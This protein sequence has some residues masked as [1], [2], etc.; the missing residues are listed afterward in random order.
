MGRSAIRCT[1]VL[2]PLALAATLV[3]TGILVTTL[4]A[5]ASGGGGCGQPVT[6]AS[7]TRVRIESFCFGPTVLRTVPGGTVT[8]RNGDTVPHTILGANGAWGSFDTLRRGQEVSYRFVR[9]GVYPYVCTYHPGMVG[10]V[11]VG[12]AGGPGA[13]GITATADGP[14]VRVRPRSVEV[15]DVGSAS[16]HV[17]SMPTSAWPI[18]LVI[19]FGVCVAGLIALVAA[20]RRRTDPT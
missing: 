12:D 13:A 1:S 20:S 17:P 14:V 18:A 8:F 19:G 4:P 5:R 7:G 10:V 11:V 6:D 15:T 2:P 16:A 3:L 9:S